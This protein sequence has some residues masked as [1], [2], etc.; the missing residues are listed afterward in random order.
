MGGEGRLLAWF[1]EAMA[2]HQPNDALSFTE[3]QANFTSVLK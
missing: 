1:F 3:A 2:R